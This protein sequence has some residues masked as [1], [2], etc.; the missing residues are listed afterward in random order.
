MNC[1]TCSSVSELLGARTMYA[2][3]TSPALTSG[4]LNNMVKITNRISKAA[5]F[6]M[7]CYTYGITT[8]STISG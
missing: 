7:K 1:L 3:G 6:E 8:A 2:I 5:R 4:N